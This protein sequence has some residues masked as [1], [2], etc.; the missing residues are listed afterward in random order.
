MD[1]FNRRLVWQFLEKFKKGRI[2]VLTTHSMEEASALGDEISVMKKGQFVAFGDAVSL[3]H[4]YGCPYRLNFNIPKEENEQMKSIIKQYIPDFKI[5]DENPLI[6][7]L[8]V[9]AGKLVDLLGYLENE[10]SVNFGISQGTLEDVFIKLM[11][12]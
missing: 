3:K 9:N 10:T 6:V 1:P 8:G 7:E 4:Q 11:R 2:I 5:I 12:Q